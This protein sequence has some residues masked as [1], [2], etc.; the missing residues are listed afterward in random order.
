LES[1]F[2]ESGFELIES[3]IWDKKMLSNGLSIRKRKHCLSKAM[4][5]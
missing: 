2:I 4:S 3:E 5:S 1:I